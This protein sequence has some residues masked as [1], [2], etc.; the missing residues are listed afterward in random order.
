MKVVMFDKAAK[1]A[2]QKQKAI[3]GTMKLHTIKGKGNSIVAVRETSFDCEKCIAY[4]SSTCESW[5]NET[6]GL[7]AKPIS[8]QSSMA[9]TID[10]VNSPR[11]SKSSK[12][13]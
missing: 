3:G 9:K 12:Y 11:G 2:K 13:T 6:I 8:G 4:S 10:E 7:I 1:L 5:R